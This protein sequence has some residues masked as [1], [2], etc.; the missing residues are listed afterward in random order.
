MAEIQNIK[1]SIL[2]TIEFDLKA[3]GHR[4]FQNFICYPMQTQ[5]SKV[6]IQ[7]NKRI[8]YYHHETGLL[9]LSKSRSNGSYQPHLV[10]DKLVEETLSDEDRLQL[11]VRLRLTDDITGN[12]VV[13]INNAGASC[14]K[15]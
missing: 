6:L 3:K 2:G 9:Q 4:G 10:F 11:N 12:K 13:K 5:S 14:I 7:S 15:I 1:K 8:G